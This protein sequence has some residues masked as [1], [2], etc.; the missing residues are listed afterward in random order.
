MY[1]KLLYTRHC[2][3]AG[4]TKMNKNSTHEGGVHVYVAHYSISGLYQ[5]AYRIGDV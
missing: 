3:R 2:A 1:I 5:S 4:D